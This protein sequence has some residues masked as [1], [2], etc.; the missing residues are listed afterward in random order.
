LSTI[1]KKILNWRVFTKD[2]PQIIYTI[3]LLI[4]IPLAFIFSGQKFLDVA[5]ENQEQLER[6]RI[7]L[8]QDIFVSSVHIG[9]HLDMEDHVFL[10]EMVEGIKKQNPSILQFKVLLKKNG[11]NTVIASL[12]K[13]EINIEDKENEQY[14][15]TSGKMQHNSFLSEVFIDGER[16]WKASSAIIDESGKI[17][18]FIFTDTSMARIDESLARNTKNAYYVLLFIIL[19]IFILLVRQ[20]K[21]INYA[22]L[23]KRLK[24]V[25]K[26][27][28]DFISM[29]AHELRTPLASIRGHLEILSSSQNFSKDG[30]ADVNRISISIERLNRLIGDMLDVARIQQGRMKFSFK[31]VKPS[32]VMQ[33][34]ADSFQPEASKK[35]IELQ[36]SSKCSAY[37]FADSGRLEQVFSNLVSNAIKYTQEGSVKII[38][39]ENHTDI[40]DFVRISVSDTGIGMSKEDQEKLFKRFSRV[41]T[42]ETADINGTGLGL[43]I[44][45]RIVSAMKG[46][47]TVKS[48]KGKGSNFTISFPFV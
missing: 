7:G 41:N 8:M 35:G 38:V 46:E 44:V 6:E 32:E 29:A 13:D 31:K 5:K 42:R 22:V 3:F 25:D 19:T 17:A 10:Q 24:G 33:S 28:D 37:I 36:Y 15:N 48:D 47:I 16:H 20:T 39:N 18:G 26:M 27:K 23:Y 2:N 34:V 30:K 21:I 14:Y 1:S 40:G 4:I 45:A 11:R 9:E 12:N 43:W